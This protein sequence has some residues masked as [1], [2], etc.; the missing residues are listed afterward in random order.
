MKHPQFILAVKAQL[1]Q[2][3]G[4]QQGFNATRIDHFLELAT[5]N[6]IIG[7][8]EALETDPA[9]RQLLPYVVLT[10]TG[11]DGVRRV[12]NYR[13]GKGV[14]ESRLLGNR[15][16]GFGGHVDFA[17]VVQEGEGS[18][19][20]LWGTVF[21]SAARELGEELGL[22]EL[23][24]ERLLDGSWG[25]IVDDSNEVGR[26]HLGLAFFVDLHP[27]TEIDLAESELSHLHLATPR[28][29]LDDH[30]KG[31]VLLENWSVILL[32]ELVRQDQPS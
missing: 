14:G 5:S 25:T 31:H 7:Q 18:L 19:I 1:V 26:V 23:D 32:Q 17:D 8:R 6:L 10:Q 4:L 11:E 3:L 12:F 27:E 9:F 2:Q 15:S 22:D 29:I 21:E 28:E 13:R 20:D 16:V 24:C 30:T